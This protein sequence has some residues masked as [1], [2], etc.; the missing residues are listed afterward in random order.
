MV[1]LEY[2]K[3][4]HRREQEEVR[5]GQRQEKEKRAEDEEREEGA[6]GYNPQEVRC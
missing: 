6:S 4:W 1:R 2:Y 5:N 3:S